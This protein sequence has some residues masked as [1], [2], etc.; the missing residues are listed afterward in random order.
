MKELRSLLPSVRPLLD[1]NFRGG[2]VSVLDVSEH[3][4]DVPSLSTVNIEP[5]IAMVDEAMR[6]DRNDPDKSDAWLAPRVHATLRL[7]RREAAER[8]IWYW[9]NVVA[10][11]DYVRWRFGGE[12][13]AS[14][15]VAL[16]RFMGEDSKNALGRLW[17]AAELT[18]NGNNY[19]ET[20]SI[21]RSSRFFASWQSLDVMHHRTAALAVCRF[22]REFNDGKGITDSQ[23]QRLAKALNL[24]LT[25]L[26]LDAI[27]PTL[28]VDVYAIEEWRARRI[29]ESKYLTKLPEGPDEEPIATENINTIF[30]VLTAL[31]EEIDLSEFKREKRKRRRSEDESEIESETTDSS[32]VNELQSATT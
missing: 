6:R 29:D 22:A 17:W 1:E 16:D 12:R 18:R 25:T 4:A 14:R 21:L 11:P 32:A 23:S 7:T 26:A 10:K 28:A 30:D 5:L 8:T 15:V 9:L 24:R 27:V 3:E 20:V 13:A 2:D 19:S 31:A